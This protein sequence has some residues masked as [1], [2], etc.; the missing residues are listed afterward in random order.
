KNAHAPPAQLALELAKQRRL[1]SHAARGD[2]EHALTAQTLQLELEMLGQRSR[3]PVHGARIG[4]R[5]TSRQHAAK[6]YRWP[7]GGCTLSK[8][9]RISWGT[10][11]SR[12]R[13]KRIHASTSW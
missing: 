5:K 8:L 3:A 13:P 12:W 7:F 9:I 2:H 1:G 10:R 11:S 4:V 6:G